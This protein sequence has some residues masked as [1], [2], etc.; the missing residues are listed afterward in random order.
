MNHVKHMLA[1]ALLTLLAACGGGGGGGS[2]SSAVT[3]VGGVASKGI[4][5]KGTVAVYPVTNGVKAGTA[6]A[7]GSIN[8][9]TYS[10]NIGDYSGPIV[11]EAYGEYSDEATGKT[12]TVPASAPLRAAL[13]YATTGKSFT[14]PVTPLTDLAYRQAI[15]SGALTATSIQAAND[16][17]SY[18]MRL[19]IINTIPAAPTLTAFASA[20]QSQKDYALILA[21]VSQV[22]ATQGTTL[23]ATLANLNSGLASTET[24]TALNNALAAYVD[25]ANT[26]NTTGVTTVPDTLKNI[27]TIGKKLTLSLS[28]NGV[29]SVQAFSV[30]LTLPDGILLR[31]NSD[32]TLLDSVFVKAGS[33]ATALNVQII[34]RYDAANRTVDLALLAPNGGLTTGNVINITCD[35]SGSTTPQASDVG[36]GNL[37]FWDQYGARILDTTLQ[38]TLSLN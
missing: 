32:G 8:N 37:K 6:L 34:A 16:Q 20:T 9:G 21:A 7:V 22:M 11:V 2:T 4:I 33:A 35:T 31:T 12:L 26:N 14:L 29:S 18:A 38:P 30:I 3:T 19:D 23:E 5:T 15:Q 17:V 36:L 13:N 27:G 24:A 25:P 10:V 28:G 1:I